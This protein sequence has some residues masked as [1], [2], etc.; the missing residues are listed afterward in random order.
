M[1]RTLGEF[2]RAC[3]GRLEG[4]DRSYTGVS[5]DSRTIG[6]GELFVALRGPNFDGNQ[7]VGPAQAAG[8]A[9]AVVDASQA[10]P[11]AQIVVDDTLQEGGGAPLFGIDGADHDLLGRRQGSKRGRRRGERKRA[12]REL[13][14]N[15]HEPSLAASR[16][17]VTTI[18]WLE[19]FPTCYLFG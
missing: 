2:A 14:S 6:A 7:F 11:L 3:G 10:S 16:L 4:A 15:L 12:Q 8:A 5:T 18:R 17:T 1:K 13:E 9:G 19:N